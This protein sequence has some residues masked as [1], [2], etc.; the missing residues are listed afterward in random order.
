MSRPAR[1]VQ[2]AYVVPPGG[3][4]FFQLGDERV[5]SPVYEL[6]LRRVDE[7]L[8]RHG[9]DTPADVALAEYMCPHMPSWFCAGDVGHSPVITVKEATAKALPYFRRRLVPVDQIV[10][11]MEACQ[12]CPRHRRDFC[13]HCNGLDEWISGGFRGKRP[14]LPADAASGC[15]TCA[16]TLEAV[17]ASVEYGEGDSV[18][19]GVPETCWRNKK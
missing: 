6:A 4:W 11:R 2:T 19:E 8:K 18:W 5:S 14:A 9:V 13:L 10:R 12:A 16:K 17:I 1:F 7:L 15:C 3:S